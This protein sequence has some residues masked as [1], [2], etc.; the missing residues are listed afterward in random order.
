[1]SLFTDRTGLKINFLTV[2]GPHEKRGKRS[3]TFWRCRCDCGNITWV[4]TT[5][6]QSGHT[7]SC[8]C[9]R[10]QNGKKLGRILEEWRKQTLEPAH[11]THGMTETKVYRAW[12]HIKARCLRKTDPNYRAYG[13]K[14]ITMFSEW[15]K[16][17][18]AF[19]AH[20][21]DPPS[22]EYTIDRID[23]AKGYEPGN[24]RWAT[25]REQSNNRRNSIRY[26]GMTILEL[27]HK[28]Q[29]HFER[30]KYLLRQRGLSLE[31]A[32]AECQ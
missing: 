6:L 11:K 18:E 4:E 26:N 25:R 7:T 10:K 14:G 19:Y 2:I 8:G 27:S 23:V 30:L 1:M 24:V 12:Q 21:G 13:A 16:S 28:H 32:L 20:I 29:V 22:P 5:N 17:F 9:Y 31:E 3:R 15:Q